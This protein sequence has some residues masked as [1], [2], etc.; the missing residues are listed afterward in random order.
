ME[1]Y[2]MSL[3][4]GTT[5]SRCIIF[6]KKGEVVSVA[7]KEFTQIYPKA[8][9]VEHDPLEIWGKQAGVAGEALNIARI[10]PEQIAG[11]G[12]TNQRE[13]TVV[14]NKRTGMP[15]Y[16]AIVWQCRRTAGYCDELREKNIDKTIKE[17]TGLMLDA[18][19]SATKIK[20][21]LD[22]VE[23]ARE[24]AEKGDLL[25]GNIDTWLIWNMTKGKVHVTDYTNASRTMLFNIHELKWDEELLEIFDIPKS[26]LPEV[27]PSSCVYGETDEILFGVSIPI[28]GDAG[29]QQAALF[30]QTC[31][32]AGMAKNTYG[33]G[34]FLLMNTGEK[35]VDSKNGLLT[36]IAV[37]IDGKVEYALEGSV[38]IGGA[39]IQWLRDEL[40]MIKT[41]Q[42]TEKY[43]TAVEDNNGVYLVPAFV[44][45][46]APYWDSY[47]RGT[48]LGLTRG[49]KK[50]HIIRAAL[51]SMAYQTHDVLKAMEEDSGIELKAL[52]VDGGACQNNFLMQFQSDILGVQVDRPEVVET[53]ALGAAYLA[54][55][56]VGYWKDRNEVSQNWAI[57]KSFDP[58][59]EDEKKEKLIKGW[60]K[61]V[62]KSMDWEEK[63]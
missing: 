7:Q 15:V 55:L 16:N 18:Y 51:E 60:H 5:S 35:A 28:S 52:K 25:F 26:M 40:R 44:G 11:I 3:D 56:A 6:N 43:A 20:W 23:G 19:F 9:W 17:K 30:G 50:E 21:I 12:I 61:A 14:W 39:V 8:G 49:A 47:A 32:N 42:E 13:T 45:I 2:I 36:T 58:A 4:Q 33:T 27:K 59:M 53:T 41:A 46:G 24:L 48:I 29:D 10:S 38:F 31:F 37:G 34:C 63:E 62:T 1:K 54:G 22:N 57:S